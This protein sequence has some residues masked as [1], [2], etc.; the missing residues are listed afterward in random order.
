MASGLLKLTG[1]LKE[2]DS[3]SRL[4]SF[5]YLA[6][7]IGDW[8][9]TA[10][11]FDFTLNVP[12]SPELED[13]FMRLQQSGAVRCAENGY[14]V[15]ESTFPTPDDGNLELL[16]KLAAGETRFLVDLSRLVYLS[17]AES[18]LGTLEERA[19]KFFL[20]GKEKFDGLM[21][22]ARGLKLVLGGG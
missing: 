7:E 21:A 4:H 19:R 1:V 12:F 3:N 8:K 17:R 2:I 22:Q 20:M 11:H 13:D 6:Q 14:V 18:D 10:Y 16:T 15:V 5:V 9:G